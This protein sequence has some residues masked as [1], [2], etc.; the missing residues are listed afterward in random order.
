MCRNS[1]NLSGT[2]S[3][4]SQGAAS[5][6]ALALVIRLTDRS[7]RSLDKKFFTFGIF[8]LFLSNVC[9]QPNQ[10]LIPSG[11]T[12]FSQ[13]WV[14]KVEH[15]PEN[16]MWQNEIETNL[17]SAPTTRFFFV[18]MPIG[19]CDLVIWVHLVGWER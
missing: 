1:H 3:N 19:P 8:S 6:P 11:E 12:K 2:Q 14:C 7:K 4:N 18:R 10:A 16:H 9:Q 15:I 17:I 13:V 5:R